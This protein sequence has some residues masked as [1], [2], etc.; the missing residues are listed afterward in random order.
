MINVKIKFKH[1]K[2]KSY[3]S[4]NFEFKDDKHFENWLLKQF[5]DH[6]YRKIIGIE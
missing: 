2:G 5:A 6:S 3:D 1:T 4:G